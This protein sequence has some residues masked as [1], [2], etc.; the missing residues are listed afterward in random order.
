MQKKR[1]SISSFSIFYQ[2]T[3]NISRGRFCFTTLDAIS[4]QF[5]LKLEKIKINENYDSNFVFTLFFTNDQS[6]EVKYEKKEK[7][8][9]FYCRL[10]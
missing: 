4:D 1:N 10:R 7:V 2:H 6:F 5:C 3:I 8:F 9:V